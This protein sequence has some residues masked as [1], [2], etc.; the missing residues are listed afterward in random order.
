M[1]NDK[2]IHIFLYLKLFTHELLLNEIVTVNCVILSTIQK[3]NR[4]GLNDDLDCI[5][6]P[7]VFLILYHFVSGK[8]F[9]LTDKMFFV[10]YLNIVNSIHLAECFNRH[11]I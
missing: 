2:K 3:M 4:S 6:I 10:I 7:T 9:F 1:T 11:I 8:C 5:I